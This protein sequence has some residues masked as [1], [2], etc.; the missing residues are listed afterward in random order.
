MTVQYRSSRPDRSG[1]LPGSSLPYDNE[2]DRELFDNLFPVASSMDCTGLIPA[3]PESSE[4][5]DSYSDIYDIP[6]ADDPARAN[7]GLQTPPKRR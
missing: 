5:V 4:E 3:A 2:D 7:H 6:L 1:H